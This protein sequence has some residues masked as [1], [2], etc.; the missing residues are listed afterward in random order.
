MHCACKFGMLFWQVF[1]FTSFVWN[2]FL[3]DC[4]LISYLS[5][6]HIMLISV[7]Q[8]QSWVPKRLPKH[9]KWCHTYSSLP[10]NQPGRITDPLGV[11][12][13]NYLQATR[14]FYRPDGKF[15]YNQI[16]DPAKLSDLIGI[17]STSNV[18]YCNPMATLPH[19]WLLL[20]CK[21]EKRST[22]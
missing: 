19:I 12:P 1:Y 2:P 4:L 18:I 11:R 16:S 3:Y 6:L 14:H 10:I 15:P 21:N 17:F 7:Q 5:M 13:K 8:S 20:L 9:R 22:A